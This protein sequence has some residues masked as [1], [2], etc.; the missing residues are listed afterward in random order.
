MLFAADAIL[1]AVISA[2]PPS[3]AFIGQLLAASWLSFAALNWNNRGQVLG[4]IYGR[5][6]VYSNVLF[7]TITA[8][9]VVKPAVVPGASPWLWVIV[10]PCGLLALVYGVLMM[11]GPFDGRAA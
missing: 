10:V 5:P 3:A 8:L 1:P 4:G 2:F 7:Y 9:G 11:R 6:L